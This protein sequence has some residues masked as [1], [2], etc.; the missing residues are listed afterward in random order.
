MTEAVQIES[1]DYW[2]KIVEMLQ[3]NWALIAPLASGYVRV[4]FINDGSGV[5]D[6]ID[7]PSAEEAINALQ[8]NGFER[9]ANSQDLQSFLSMPLPPFHRK[10]H[11]NGPIYSSGRFWTS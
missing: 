5:F 11:P 3:Q 4:Y 1:D 9:Y 8:R 6:E 10:P 2:V 7:F